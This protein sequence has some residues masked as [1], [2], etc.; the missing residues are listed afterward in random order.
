MGGSGRRLLVLSS[1]VGAPRG[2]V[3]IGDVAQLEAALQRLRQYSPDVWPVLAPNSL[4][5]SLPL[6]LEG[7]VGFL[8]EVR[9]LL[10]PRRRTAAVRLP[11][12][13]VE[14]P[15]GWPRWLREV[16]QHLEAHAGVFGAGAGLFADA[17]ASDIGVLW[18]TVFTLARGLGLPVALSGQQ[19]GPLRRWRTRKISRWALS[20][21]QIVGARDRFSH[22]EA[23]AL[24]GRRSRVVFSGDDAWDL[25]S[26]RA[27]AAEVLAA[28]GIVDEYIVWQARFGSRAAISERHARVLARTLDGLAGM[29]GLRLVF[30]PFYVG[31]VRDDRAAARLVASR[32][33]HDVTV[34]EGERRPAVV[35]GIVEGAQ[36]AVG[37]A[38]HFAVFAASSGVPVLALFDSEYMGR[39]LRGLAA[40]APDTVRAV[41]LPA[42]SRDL[43]CT[44]QGLV[45]Y[46]GRVPDFERHDVLRDLLELI[47]ERR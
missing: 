5:E 15:R 30:V 42:E 26:D 3:N 14:G 12:A 20:Q 31:G 44:A 36:L 47:E 34:V 37:T 16:V 6:H 10:A 43:V 45:A 13:A 24:L 39:K 33:R 35:K 17:F 1:G 38:N 22:A 28:H 23:A 19:V 4:A 40:L 25:T 8:P 29:L 7:R 18:G 46:R 32:M 2:P 21:A 27:A 41:P 11:L 9:R